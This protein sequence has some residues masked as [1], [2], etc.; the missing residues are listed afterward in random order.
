MGSEVRVRQC[1]K[2]WEEALKMLIYGVSAVTTHLCTGEMKLLFK[3]IIGSE[4]IYIA[5]Q[6]ICLSFFGS[7]GD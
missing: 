1:N 4:C 6:F 2:E 3:K 5:T 7:A